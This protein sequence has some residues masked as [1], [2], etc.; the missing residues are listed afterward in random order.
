MCSK[1][2]N[3]MMQMKKAPPLKATLIIIMIIIILLSVIISI[4]KKHTFEPDFKEEQHIDATL[5]QDNTTQSSKVLTTKSEAASD[6]T[7]AEETS[8]LHDYYDNLRI[9][10]SRFS[11]IEDL[12]NYYLEYWEKNNAGKT[13]LEVIDG[14]DYYDAEICTAASVQYLI[15]N[16]KSADDFYDEY[17]HLQVCH[18]S[19]YGEYL[20]VD[21]LNDLYELFP[22]ESNKYAIAKS[23]MG[24]AKEVIVLNEL[25]KGNPVLAFEANGCITKETAQIAYDIFNDYSPIYDYFGIINK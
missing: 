16:E 11:A 2:D 19:P 9:K 10:D 14:V 7:K 18:L 21:E 20:P 4:I 25:D 6:V 8:S 17:L 23:Y 24:L 1:K 3:R 5:I 22:K 13:A 12:T 15:Q